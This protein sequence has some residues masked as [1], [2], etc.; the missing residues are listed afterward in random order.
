MR[1][2]SPTLRHLGLHYYKPQRS[3]LQLLDA[4][5]VP[6]QPRPLSHRPHSDWPPWCARVRPHPASLVPVPPPGVCPAHAGHLLHSHWSLRCARR[7][8]PAPPAPWPRA[9]RRP[10]APGLRLLSWPQLPGPTRALDVPA[11]AWA[12]RGRRRRVSAVGR[13]WVS[14]IRRSSGDAGPAR[15]EVL[16]RRPCRCRGARGRP[17]GPGLRPRLRRPVALTP[18]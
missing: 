5:R 6:R 3:G 4:G 1:V 12:R 13:S 8:A 2:L 9:R 17:A 7:L 14:V 11:P 10:P 18:P 16:W 15:P